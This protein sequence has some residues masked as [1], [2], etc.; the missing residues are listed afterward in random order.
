MDALGPVI[1]KKKK[2]AYTA[3]TTTKQY[4]FI[5]NVELCVLWGIVF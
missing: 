1:K 5:D 3:L 4:I 2:V